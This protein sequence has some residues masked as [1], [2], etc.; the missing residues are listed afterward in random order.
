[1]LYFSDKAVDESRSMFLPFRCLNFDY[2]MITVIIMSNV[3]LQFYPQRFCQQ[4]L[5]N[6]VS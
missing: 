6:K 3:L 4:T 1:M 2:S 5:I